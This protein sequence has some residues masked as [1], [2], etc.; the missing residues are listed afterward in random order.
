VFRSL[1]RAHTCQDSAGPLHERTDMATHRLHD[2]SP[3]G[4]DGSGVSGLALPFG[5]SMQ[6]SV[7][8]L[9]DAALGVRDAWNHGVLPFRS[10][11]SICGAL[12]EHGSILRVRR[13]EHIVE[14]AE[15]ITEFG[16]RTMRC[17][18]P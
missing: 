3:V 4:G 2:A 9:R 10:P 13:G 18:S 7:A 12:V 15:C 6:L 5:L 1:L 16:L 8:E 14:I 11:V 17:C